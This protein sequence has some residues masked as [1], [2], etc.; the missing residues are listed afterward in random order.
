MPF[1]G[2]RAR[3]ARE[4]ASASDS[5]ELLCESLVVPGLPESRSSSASLLAGT[6]AAD[7]ESDAL[8]RCER[9]VSFGAEEE[10]DKE[11]SSVHSG[12]WPFAN[13]LR[14]QLPLASFSASSFGN[15]LSGLKSASASKYLFYKGTRRA[16]KST[17]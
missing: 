16:N 7:G 13:P 2:E 3:A 6:V 12:R 10:A 1:E 17:A 14:T 5:S 9:R 15:L 8:A 4:S 11:L